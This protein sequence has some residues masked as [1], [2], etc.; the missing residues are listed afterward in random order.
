[1]EFSLKFAGNG[2]VEHNGRS[3]VRNRPAGDKDGL[4][5]AN[6]GDTRLHKVKNLPPKPFGDRFIT[7]ADA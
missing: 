1:M 5:K 6:Q 2:S 7:D 4:H 3:V